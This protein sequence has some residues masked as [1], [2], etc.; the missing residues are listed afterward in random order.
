MDF[1]FDLGTVVKDSVTGFEG[2]TIS[3]CNYFNGGVYYCLCSQKLTPNRNP[4]EW[5]YFDETRLITVNETRKI[6][7]GDNHA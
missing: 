3:R 7:D 4:V 1:K 5:R 2:V 6:Y